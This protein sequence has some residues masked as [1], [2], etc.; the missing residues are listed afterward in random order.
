MLCQHI[1]LS[2]TPDIKNQQNQNQMK[3]GIS[4]GIQHWLNFTPIEVRGNLKQK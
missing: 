3:G 1:L 4:K 2:P